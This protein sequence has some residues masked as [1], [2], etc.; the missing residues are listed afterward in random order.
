MPVGAE[1]ELYPIVKRF[2][3]ERF[4]QLRQPPSAIA[5]WKSEHTPTLGIDFPG[6]WTRPD[7]A[8]VHVWRH[9]FAPVVNVDLHS[10]EV[11]RSDHCT[12]ISVFEALA[13]TRIAHFAHVVWHRPEPT[14]QVERFRSVESSCRAFG[15]GLIS[16][17]DHTDPASFTVHSVEARRASPDP[18]LVDRFIE[19][20][21]PDH[22]NTISSWLP[23]V[24]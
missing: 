8:A 10:F 14:A 16:F 17:S 11:K 13:H 6:R 15:V 4:S 12:E 18:I 7:L 21:F 20:A 19:A 3:D 9:K 24:G 1:T 5:L 23:R 22:I 2:L